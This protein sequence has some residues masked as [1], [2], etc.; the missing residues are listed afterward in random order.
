MSNSV[1]F[2]LV[3]LAAALI[4]SVLLWLLSRARRPQEPAPP[5]QQLQVLSPE[6]GSRPRPQPSGIVPL[7]TPPDEER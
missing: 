7:D 5:H 2:L 3:P 6:Q 4:G 1:N